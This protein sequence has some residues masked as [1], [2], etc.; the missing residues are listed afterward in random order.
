MLFRVALLQVAVALWT[1]APRV[2]T[3]HCDEIPYRRLVP[4]NHETG[5]R[6]NFKGERNPDS[7]H[8]AQTFAG[9]SFEYKFSY[10]VRGGVFYARVDE[11]H[12]RSYVDESRSWW[13]KP[14]DDPSLLRHE[15]GHFDITELRVRELN[16]LKSKSLRR[17]KVRGLSADAVEDTLHRKLTNHMHR[18]NEALIRGEQARYDAETQHGGDRAQQQRWDEDLSQRLRKPR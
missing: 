4:P 12:Y 2:S 11:L 1:V 18:E 7:P 5:G 17:L 6:G 13:A 10:K 3:T 15:Q 9:M 8:A 14:C 16:Q